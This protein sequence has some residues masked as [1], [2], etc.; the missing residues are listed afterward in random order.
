MHIP[1][2]VIMFMLLL[3]AACRSQVSG[4]GVGTA[5]SLQA[6]SDVGDSAAMLSLAYCYQ[7]GHGVTADS[8]KA[9]QLYK[10][11]LT[12]GYTRV[13]QFNDSLARA[14]K[15]ILSSLL[16]SE[17]YAKGIGTQR[18]ADLSNSYLTMAA[19]FGHVPSQYRAALY[20]MDSQRPDKAIRWF[21]MAAD[22]GE[23]GALYYTGLLLY[24]G[25][26]VTQD[27]EKGMQYLMQAADSSFSAAHYQLGRIYLTGDGVQTDDT[28]G[29]AH[30]LKATTS[31][32]ARW[33]LA[34][35]YAQGK[36]V[37]QDYEQALI[38]MAE[39]FATRKKELRSFLAG[40]Q[41]YA[42]YIDSVAKEG[43]PG[44]TD[45]KLKEKINNMLD[46]IKQQQ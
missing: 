24:Q 6:K 28:L 15:S 8:A 13:L 35:C 17:C 9:V 3:S 43:L 29:V 37:A 20:Y 4:S 22:N 36:G 39:T 38:L 12:K 7:K 27:R 31:S 10:D 1:R 19:T 25:R 41:P 2:P 23:V 33:M 44:I 14:D 30:L 46:V 40:N 5:D 45:E 34:K 32:S 21:R 26:G 11:A 16:L 18:D 42:H